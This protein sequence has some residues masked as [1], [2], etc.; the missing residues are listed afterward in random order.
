MCTQLEETQ[1]ASY[2]KSEM[3]IKTGKAGLNT[4][5]GPE[6]WHIT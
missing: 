5:S 6:H 3:L 2:F 4:K 1:K